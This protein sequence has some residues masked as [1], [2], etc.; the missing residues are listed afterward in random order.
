[1]VT[2]LNTDNFE[3]Q[4]STQKKAFVIKFFSPTCGPCHTMKPV[5]DKLQ[6]QNQDVSIFEIDS[7]ESPELAAHFGVRGVPSILICEGREVLYQF[8]GVTPFRDI[9]YVLDNLDDVHFRSTGVFKVSEKKQD[10]FFPAIA[11][12]LLLFFIILFIVG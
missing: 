7:S 9:Q 6:E 2:K 5:I 11:L 3:E 1:M 10:L 12:G 4:V 8:T